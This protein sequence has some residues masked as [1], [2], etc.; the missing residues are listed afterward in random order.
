[1]IFHALSFCFGVKAVE[2]AFITILAMFSRGSHYPQQHTA[3]AAAMTHPFVPFCACLLVVSEPF[4]ACLLAA[5][6]SKSDK[7]SSS[8]LQVCI[9]VHALDL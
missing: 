3:G 9:G 8:G 4:C 1:M 7:L 6:E 2:Q 5:D